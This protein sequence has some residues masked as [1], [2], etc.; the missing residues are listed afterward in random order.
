MARS[1]KLPKLTGRL[2]AGK[3]RLVEITLNIR[4]QI[5]KF[6]GVYNLYSSFERYLVRNKKFRPMKDL[7]DICMAIVKF[8][9]KWEYFITDEF[10]QIIAGFL[11]PSA[12]SGIFRSCLQK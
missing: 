3:K 2:N 9:D 8:I 6:Y 10:I 12:T 7:A 1:Q 5:G 4:I 11:A